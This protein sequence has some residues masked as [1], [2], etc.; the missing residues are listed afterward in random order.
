MRTHE[1]INNQL[2]MCMN[3]QFDIKIMNLDLILIAIS[4]SE[5]GHDKLSRAVNNCNL[6]LS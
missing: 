3:A 1:S 2:V 4:A 6:K 5:L